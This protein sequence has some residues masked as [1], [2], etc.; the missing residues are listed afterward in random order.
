MK[1]KTTK[2]NVLLW[3][4]LLGLAQTPLMAQTM[5]LQQCLDKA[6]N[7]NLQLKA[8]GY[9]LEKSKAGVKEAY[10]AFLPTVTATTNYEY[11][12]DMT[13]TA[14]PAEVFGGTPGTYNVVELG[15]PQSKSTITQLEQKIISPASVLA[16]KASKA[17]V[18]LDM[19]EIRSSKEELVYNV[20]VT[21]YNIQSLQ[22]QIQLNTET[23]KSTETLLA[24]S[25]S[26]LK[27]GLVTQ[28]DV[29]RLTVSRDN[30][31]AGIDSLK[32]SLEKYYNLLKTFMYMPLTDVVEVFPFDAELIDAASL[33]E[34]TVDPKN[35]TDFMQIQESITIAN[36]QRKS[37]KSIN[38]PTL[39]FTAKQGY[40]GSYTNADPFKNINDKFYPV[41]SIGFKLKVTVFD[42]VTRNQVR[43][44]E[45]EIKKYQVQGE[46]VVQQINREVADAF[47]DLKS[48]YITY[49]NQTRNLT[50]AQK[51]MND[52]DKQYKNGI[53]KLSDVLNSRTELL[54]AQ[55]AYTVSIINI[56]QAELNLR[57]AQ[58]KLIL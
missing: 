13:T 8:N 16:I 14:L 9:D 37:I 7:Q 53:S 20:S 40:T 52:V 24:I 2:L 21:Y 31:K 5:S 41:S 57:K 49:Q 26:Q 50:L 18:K 12:F 4:A 55:N 56:K 3:L 34:P 48:N 17:K 45:F 33:V 39:S 43:Q 30:S 6:L 35:R 1:R 38:Y 27:S 15:V 47:A 46:Q 28:T 19:L 36:L 29:D 42:G 44:K 11:Q 54:T 51:V 58:G 23:L 25:E 22:K 10:G 32:N